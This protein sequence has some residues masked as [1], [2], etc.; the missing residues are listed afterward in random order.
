MPRPSFTPGCALGPCA[1][2]A[3]TASAWHFQ[4]QEAQR[5]QL[6]LAVPGELA[7]LGFKEIC[8][9]IFKA[10]LKSGKSNSHS[11]N[12]PKVVKTLT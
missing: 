11:L 10:T 12:L 3:A 9:E 8:S 5:T 2:G 7:F 1:E 4:V 6:V